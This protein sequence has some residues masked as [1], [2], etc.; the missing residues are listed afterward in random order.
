[1]LGAGD[2]HEVLKSPGLLRRHYSPQ[3]KLVLWSWRDEQD[4]KVQISDF[5]F[6]G[7]RFKVQSSKVQLSKIHVIAHTHIPSGEG[8]GRVSVI[9]RDATAFAQAIYAELHECDEAGAELIVV[10]APPNRD[11][12]RPIVD[13]LKKAA[14]S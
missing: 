4:L 14:S 7:S 11:E 8:F 10:E 1:A 12:W 2:S 3:A 5:R 9:S 13:R 6:Q